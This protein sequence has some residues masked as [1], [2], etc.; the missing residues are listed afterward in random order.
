MVC[1]VIS[2]TTILWRLSKEVN[3]KAL[4]GSDLQ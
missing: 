3:S 4:V 1:T 2:M